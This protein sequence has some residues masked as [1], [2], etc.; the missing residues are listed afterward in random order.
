MEEEVEPGIIIEWF[1]VEVGFTRGAVAL[2]FALC[3][4]GS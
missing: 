3:S 4:C 1:G 2:I